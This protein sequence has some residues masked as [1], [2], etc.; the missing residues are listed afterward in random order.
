M[1]EQ[2]SDEHRGLLTLL[3]LTQIQLGFQ[4]GQNAKS[5]K[6]HWSETNSASIRLILD[7]LD[8]VFGV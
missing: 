4:N 2:E 6:V 1:A 8:I 3:E 7:T 5:T